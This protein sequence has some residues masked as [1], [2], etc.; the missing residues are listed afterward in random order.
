M[1]QHIGSKFSC[2]ENILL[3][4]LAEGQSSGFQI[5]NGRT[6]RKG[7][8]GA[9]TCYPPTFESTVLFSLSFS[10]HFSVASRFVAKILRENQEKAF[11]V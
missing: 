9:E 1:A 6:H 4:L 2:T 5:L 11:Y 7:I 3:F 8:T 10:L